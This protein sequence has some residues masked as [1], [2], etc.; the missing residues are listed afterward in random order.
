MPSQ[1]NA[2]TVPAPNNVQGA[3]YIVLCCVLVAMTTLIARALGP[4]IAGEAALHPV[5]V[6][7]ARFFFGACTI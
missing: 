5:Q 7:W 1:S 2:F 3:A 4:Q 6:S